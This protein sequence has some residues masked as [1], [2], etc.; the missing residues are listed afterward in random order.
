MS[1]LLFIIIIKYELIIQFSLLL[2]Q[3]P[4]HSIFNKPFK[5]DF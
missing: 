1:Y 5:L 3:I 4:L 2:L